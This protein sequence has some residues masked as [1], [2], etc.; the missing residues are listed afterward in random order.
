[1]RDAWFRTGKSVYRF[2]TRQLLKWEDNQGQGP[3]M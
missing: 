2:V 3:K 1:V